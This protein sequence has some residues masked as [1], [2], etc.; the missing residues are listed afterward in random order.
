MKRYSQRI[1]EKYQEL[2]RKREDTTGSYQRLDLFIK[3][4]WL[5]CPNL[6]DSS[7]IKKKNLWKDK[8]EMDFTKEILKLMKIKVSRQTA[9]R[10]DKE[11]EDKNKKKTK[12]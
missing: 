3:V 2:L 10:E 12:K 8:E 1:L 5:F 9:Y 6:T 11:K 7:N 4:L